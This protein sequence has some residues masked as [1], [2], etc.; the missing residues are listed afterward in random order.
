MSSPGRGAVR[1]TQRKRSA[2]LVN[3]KYE[4][5]EEKDKITDGAYR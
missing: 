2:L 4:K 3:A 5:K 1:L